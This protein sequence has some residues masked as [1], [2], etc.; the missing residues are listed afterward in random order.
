MKKFLALFAAA[1]VMTACTKKAE[2]AP[3]DTMM[4]APAEAPADETSDAP[5]AEA[6]VDG[7]SSSEAAK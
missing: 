4:E 3:A 1:V 5:A 2:E 7:A 6:P